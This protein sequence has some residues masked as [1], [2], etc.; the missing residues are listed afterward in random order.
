MFIVVVYRVFVN[1][2]FMGKIENWYFIVYIRFYL[3][4][5]VVVVVIDLIDLFDVVFNLDF[6][7][8]VF[9]L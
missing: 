2:D 6:F 4:I 5:I 3:E 8:V 7:S 1:G 9:V